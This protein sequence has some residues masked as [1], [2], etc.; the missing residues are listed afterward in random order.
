MVTIQKSVQLS[1]LY[2]IVDYH[3]SRICKQMH[4]EALRLMYFK[5]F[6]SFDNIFVED[7]VLQQPTSP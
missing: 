7:P 4:L 3:V 2:R 1:I 5:R 6:Q